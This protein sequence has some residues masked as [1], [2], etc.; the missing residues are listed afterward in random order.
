MSRQT[1]MVQPV[2]E[3]SFPQSTSHNHLRLCVLRP[4][5]RHI[6][7]SLFCWE[8]IHSTHFVSYWLLYLFVHNWLQISSAILFIIIY[9]NVRTAWLL[10]Q[11]Q[12]ILHWYKSEEVGVKSFVQGDFR[13]FG[14]WMVLV[15]SREFRSLLPVSSQ[16]T[17]SKAAN[18]RENSD[19][20]LGL[21]IIKWRFW[22][23]FTCCSL[24]LR[25]TL[26]SP[27]VTL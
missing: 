12:A 17:V 3:S 14:R 18:S 13:T 26:V 1:L 21:F 10:H 15:F 11:L 6:G 2:T 4:N 16:F 27:R 20:N 19:N 7:V 23:G 24:K 22:L 8:F 9:Y 25:V 5:C